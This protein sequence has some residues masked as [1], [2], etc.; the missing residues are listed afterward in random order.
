MFYVH[1]V[2]QT[3]DRLKEMLDTINVTY[4]ETTFETERSAAGLRELVSHL[5]T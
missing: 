5:M 1:L 4:D 2:I 3:M